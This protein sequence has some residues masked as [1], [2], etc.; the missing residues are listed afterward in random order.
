MTLLMTVSVMTEEVNIKIRQQLLFEERKALRFILNDQIPVF[1]EFLL[2]TSTWHITLP[3]AG[4]SLRSYF[5]QG[6]GHSA[7]VRTS[8]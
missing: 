4:K 7:S 2:W 1:Y 8:A 6:N 5:H 3:A